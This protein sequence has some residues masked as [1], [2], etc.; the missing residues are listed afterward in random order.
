[1]LARDGGGLRYGCVKCTRSE[2]AASVAPGR[3]NHVNLIA[4]RICSDAKA[5]VFW[6]HLSGYR[7]E[8]VLPYSSWYSSNFV[9]TENQVFGTPEVLASPRNTVEYILQHEPSIT[10]VLGRSL[11][12]SSFFH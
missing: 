9:C 3:H 8:L 12:E 4:R 10:G 1:M 2:S 6:F 5:A 7:Y 11:H